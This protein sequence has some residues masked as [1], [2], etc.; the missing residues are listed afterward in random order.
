MQTGI[1]L[2]K[3]HIYK[4]SD[5]NYGAFELKEQIQKY[6]QKAA[7]YTL[8]ALFL[9]LLFVWITGKLT[10]SESIEILRL[11]VVKVEMMDL[12]PA[13]AE[14]E[15]EIPPAPPTPTVVTGGPAARA[16][17]PIPIPDAEISP[18]LQ[19][20]ASTDDMFRA[21]AEGGDGVDLGGFSENIDFNNTGLEVN[22]R[23]EEPDPDEFI[24]VQELPKV[25]ISKIM[26][27]IE[28]PD[29]A[30]RSGIE[31]QV[32]LKVLVGKDGTITKK[33]IEYSDNSLL[34]QAALDAISKYGKATPAI[35]NNAP[36]VC[37][38]TIP[39]K[40]KLTN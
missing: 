15:I 9:I 39:I 7:I 18:D 31:G 25:D 2:P 14:Q 37:W 26:G 24:A 38:L 30:K 36:V 32:V 21:S 35:Q 34:N 20:F 28:Y 4:E 16:G 22:V 40:F 3:S 27:L 17:T 5:L 19:E 29:I 10:K 23:E 12:P 8:S 33:K 11:E 13:S 6:S 1:I